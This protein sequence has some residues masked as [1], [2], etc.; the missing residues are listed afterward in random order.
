[1]SNKK[2]PNRLSRRGIVIGGSAALASTAAIA[3]QSPDQAIAQQ[4]DNTPSSVAGRL[5]GKVAIITGAAR[6]IG[7]ACAIALAKE[8]ANIVAM[9]I[10]R[11]IDG[12][13]YSLATP[14]DLA[15]TIQLVEAEGR[16][17]L[18]IQADV[19]DMSQMTNVVQRSLQEFGKIDILVANAGVNASASLR[20]VTDQQ[21]R[22]IIDVNLIGVANSIRAVL[23][24]F[25]ERE[26]GSIVAISS[27]FGR[28][29]TGVGLAHYAASKWGI[30]G[31]VKAAALEVAPHN[32][33]VNAVAP[34]AVRTG[35][36]GG[37]P[38]DPAEREAA[39][40]YLLQYNALP[41]AVLEPSDVAESVVFLVSPQARYI[42][43]AVLDVAAGANARYTA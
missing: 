17:C 27:T 8:G 30:I 32:V 13:S 2:F 4:P 18:N 41:V 19:R 6:G 22:T 10:T 31:L 5:N 7:R 1:M 20:D 35:L 39:E 12:L 33:T 26:Q 40:R 38:T 16:R 42:T 21:W 3:F 15:E 14:A 9:D 23:P 11:N 25:I 43:G 28:Q 36:G 24:H 29:G 37:A 34:T